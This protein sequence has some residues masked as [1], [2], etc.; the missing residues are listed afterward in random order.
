[1]LQQLR[2]FPLVAVLVLV[3]TATACGDD[4]PTDE[5]DDDGTS[6][7]TFTYEP[8]PNAPEITS[9]AV[10][11]EFNT[12]PGVWSPTDPGFQMEEQ[13]DGSWELTVEL[14]PGT[15]EYKYH[16]NGSTWATDMCNDMTFGDA[17]GHVSPQAEECNAADNGNAIITVVDDND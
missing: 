1:M 8:G 14:A 15:Y 11:G 13:A 17:S 2:R 5:D 4:D 12:N 3:A 10:P 7:V 9:V 6:T 16:F